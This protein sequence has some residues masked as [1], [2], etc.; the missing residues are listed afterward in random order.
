LYFKFPDPNGPKNAGCGSGYAI[1]NAYPV[2]IGLYN[3]AIGKPDPKTNNKNIVPQL[4]CCAGDM[5]MH[6]GEGI[7][8]LDLSAEIS[9]EEIQP[10]LKLKSSVQ[11]TDI[12]FTLK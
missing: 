3:V 2:R 5:V 6:G 4:S 12:A 7:Y 1:R 9:R 8:R 11:V 10:E